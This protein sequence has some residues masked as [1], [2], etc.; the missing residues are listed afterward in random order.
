MRRL[1][2]ATFFAGSVFGWVAGAFFAVAFVAGFGAAFFAGALRVVVLMSSFVGVGAR[3]RV[4]T[5]VRTRPACGR[6]T[7][8][9]RTATSLLVRGEM[10]RASSLSR[11]REEGYAVLGVGLS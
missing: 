10:W 1:L 4:R 5:R 7:P 11:H 2:A 3:T 9:F 8:K 6:S